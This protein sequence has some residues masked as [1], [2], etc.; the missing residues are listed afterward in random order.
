MDPEHSVGP[1]HDVDPAHSVDPGLPDVDTGLLSPV[2]AGTEVERVTS[3]RAWLQAMLDAEAA[4]ARAQARLGLVPGWAAETITAA[5]QA[6][7]VDLVAIARRS[8]DAANPVV[9]LVHE[10]TVAV[11]RADPEAAEYVHRGST[12]Q[13]ILDTGAMLVAARALRVILRDLGRVA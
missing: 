12:S 9:A 3:D 10:L 7:N 2:R 11:A 8:R 13:D 1:E 5:A 6:G 4:L